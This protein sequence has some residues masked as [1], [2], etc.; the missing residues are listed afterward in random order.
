M[1]RL[2]V[3]DSSELSGINAFLDGLKDP[4]YKV[5]LA[6][7]EAVKK[8]I[9]ALIAV[10]GKV[11]E[12]ENLLVKQM[13]L[14][15]GAQKL[16]DEA[17]SDRTSASAEIKSAK[18]AAR[19]FIDEREATALA[20]ISDRQQALFDGERALDARSKVLEEENTDLLSRESDLALD[21]MKAEEIRTKYTEAVAS[22]KTALADVQKAL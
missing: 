4:V 10:H 14:T 13:Q 5:R 18:A 7:L 21:M 17:M 2:P 6:E 22:L 15:E 8:E 3:L 12:I 19:K 20:T 16:A 9:N 11:S 1:K